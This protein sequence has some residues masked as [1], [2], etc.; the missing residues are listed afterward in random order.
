MITV[1]M[2]EMLQAG[3]HFGHQTRYWNP[4]MDKFIFGSRNKIHILNLDHTVPAFNEVL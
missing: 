4:K 2:K 3:V 1:S